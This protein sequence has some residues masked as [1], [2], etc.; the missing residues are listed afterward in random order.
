M[1]SKIIGN[2]EFNCA[3]C[4]KQYLFD[5]TDCGFYNDTNKESALLETVK[6]FSV[7]NQTCKNCQQTLSVHFDV[8]EKPVGVANYMA[9]KEVGITALSY[10]F[11]ISYYDHVNDDIE[12]YDEGEDDD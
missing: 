5:A 8:W 1:D 7:L 10:E 2:A 4:H 6:Y 11:D 3:N 9:H 12:A